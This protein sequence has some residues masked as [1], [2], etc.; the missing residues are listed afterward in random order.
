MR[1]FQYR[2]DIDGL[3]A[4]AVLGV[5]LFHAGLGCPG[6][7]VGVDVFFVISGFLIT[8]IVRR[9]IDAGSF[10]MLDFWVRRIRRILPAVSFMTFVILLSGFLVLDPPALVRLS[11]EV[12]AQSL[13]MANIYFYHGVNYFGEAS[14]FK[15]LVHTWSL[16]VEEQFYVIFPGILFL[17]S[18]FARKRMALLV[19]GLLVISFGLNLYW[20]ENKPSAAFYLLPA[21]AWELLAGALMAIIQA[22]FTI[23]RRIGGLLSFSGFAMILGAMFFFTAETPFPGMAALLPVAGTVLVLIGNKDGPTVV[24]RWLSWRPVVFIGLISYSLY[25]WHWPLLVFPRLILIK[26]GGAI[27]WLALAVSFPLAALSWKY[28]EM[29]FRG[30]RTSTRRGPVFAF[31]LTATMAVLVPGI[32]LVRGGGYPERL[33][34]RIQT[35]LSDIPVGGLGDAY[36]YKDKGISIGIMKQP[37]QAEKGYDFALVGDS[38]GLAI[39]DTVHRVASQYGLAGL[40][41]L[42]GGEPPVTGLWKK[43]HDKR[44]RNEI[45]KRSEAIAKELIARDV[46]N[47]I[48]VSRWSSFCELQNKSFDSDPEGGF[49]AAMGAMVLDRERET[50][51]PRNSAQS[52]ARQ[53]KIMLDRLNAAGI[54]VW[55]VKQFPEAECR[56]IANTF[57]LAKR[58]PR[59]NNLPPASTS[60]A[61]HVARQGRVNAILDALASARVHVIDPTPA[62]FPHGGP[63]TIY[64]DR[65]YY[66]DNHHLSRYGSDTF[67][68]PVLDEIFLGIGANP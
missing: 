42:R 47:V 7:Y 28:V 58:F 24:G 65:A 13:M 51:S 34:E 64:G 37:D 61:A 44:K 1:I 27:P 26:S 50:I 29:P 55:I 9:D 21:R 32:L 11:K 23:H 19:T 18:L 20:M 22:D 49:S 63:L 68:P 16:A 45:L 38:H 6:G 62:F 39:A 3:R 48:F 43:R 66:W 53:F 15:L 4:V 30:K 14:N 5:L 8:S 31:G 57:Y 52:L 40:C 36:R 2:P 33:D 35:L 41:F 46:R 12:V 17:I 10:S 56:R 60:F 67:M 25:L 54:D 59:L